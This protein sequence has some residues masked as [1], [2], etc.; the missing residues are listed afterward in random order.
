[1]SDV[2]RIDASLG[3]G[4]ASCQQCSASVPHMPHPLRR[5]YSAPSLVALNMKV[6]Q[7]DTGVNI[8]GALGAYFTS[9]GGPA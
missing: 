2:G 8:D 4:E 9:G 3:P 1:M 7:G 6:T 5:T